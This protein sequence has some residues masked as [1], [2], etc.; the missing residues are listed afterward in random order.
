MAQ[1]PADAFIA[2][3]H[4]IDNPDGGPALYGVGD[5]IPRDEAVRLGL[6]ADTPAEKPAKAPA[7]RMTRAKKGPAEDRAKKPAED[8]AKK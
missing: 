5:P 1:E 2:A 6:I 3:P 8:R 7:K 4:R